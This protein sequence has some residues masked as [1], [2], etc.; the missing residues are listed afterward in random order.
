MVRKTMFFLR[1]KKRNSGVLFIIILFLLIIIVVADYDDV[2]YPLTVL[3]VAL[4][5]GCIGVVVLGVVGWLWR[6]KVC[7]L[8]CFCV[9]L[10]P[11]QEGQRKA[12]DPPAAAA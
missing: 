1:G 2:S 10:L 7:L 11:V 4:N 5:S 9:Y 3:G 8:V 12:T 6:W